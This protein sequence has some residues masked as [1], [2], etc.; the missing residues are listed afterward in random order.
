MGRDRRNLI[1]LTHFSSLIS[2]K[3]VCNIFEIKKMPNLAVYRKTFL[4]RKFLESSGIFHQKISQ[5]FLFSKSG[6]FAKKN[7]IKDAREETK[8]KKKKKKKKKKKYSAL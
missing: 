2:L 5:T 1:V 7:I 8:N 4:F 6:V 3:V